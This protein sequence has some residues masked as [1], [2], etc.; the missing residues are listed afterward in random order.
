MGRRMTDEINSLELLHREIL[1]LRGQLAI[2]TKLAATAIS[3][4]NYW[5][6]RYLGPDRDGNNKT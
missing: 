6:A 3:E 4:R 5:R 2:A 1:T